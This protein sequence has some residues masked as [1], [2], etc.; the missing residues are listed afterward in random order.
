MK[1]AFIVGMCLLVL[2]VCFCFAPLLILWGLNTLLE[3]ASTGVYIPHSFWTYMAVIAII[4]PLN[5][6]KVKS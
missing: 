2:A 3:A 6:S 1:D 5:A 4:L